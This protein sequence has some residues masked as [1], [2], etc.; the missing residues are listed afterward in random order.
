M[1]DARGELRLW[2][3]HGLRPKLARAASTG[4]VDPVAVAALDADLRTFLDLGRPRCEF[5]GSAAS[6]SRSDEPRPTGLSAED[7]RLMGAAPRSRTPSS[8]RSGG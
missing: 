1:K 6:M 5:A 7:R 8:D 4:A 3:L 2:Y